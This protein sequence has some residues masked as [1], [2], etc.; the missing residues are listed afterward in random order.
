MS[1][2]GDVETAL[3]TLKSRKFIMEFVASEKLKP[4]LFEDNWNAEKQEWNQDSSLI[5]KIKTWLLPVSEG[6]NTSEM[7]EPGEPSSWTVFEKFSKKVL[8][9]T[10][11]KKTG[12]VTLAVEWRDP[13]LAAQW[14][15]RLVV[16]LN[17][18]LRQRA[19]EEGEKSIVFL[20]QQIEQTSIADLR[21]V[22]FK[23]IEEHIK[24][25]TLAKVND[26]Y[27]LKVIDPAVP[28]EKTTKP[29]RILIVMLGF[30]LGWGLSILLVFVRRAFR[31]A[32]NKMQE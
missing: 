18:E 25:I 15:N 31:V 5:K 16:K 2:G 8:S 22:L 27:A 17:L 14:A 13:I 9:V 11:D 32:G 1:G 28:P 7:L 3:A 4:A 6:K 19:V 29:K 24:S 20:E 30:T 26:E 10:Q 12:L 21:S 23:L